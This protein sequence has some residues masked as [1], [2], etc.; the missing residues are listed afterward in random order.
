MQ[1]TSTN[2]DKHL[3]NFPANTI[4]QGSTIFTLLQDAFNS[5]TNPRFE[6]LKYN[7]HFHILMIL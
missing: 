5:N 7:F 6:I 2:S 1:E 3:Q 4:A